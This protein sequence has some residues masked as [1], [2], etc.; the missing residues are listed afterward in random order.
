M[1]SAWMPGFSANETDH[2]GCRPRSRVHI[3]NRHVA[4]AHGSVLSH[5]LQP[6][7][8]RPHFVMRVR[9]GI[10]H[11]ATIATRVPRYSQT[12]SLIVKSCQFSS[13]ACSGCRGGTVIARLA[14]ISLLHTRGNK[15]A[16]GVLSHYCH[17]PRPHS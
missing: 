15:G 3:Q 16:C 7:I 8:Y 2:L 10:K 11:R 14:G 17:L 9:V 12:P 6:F 4:V 1:A 5:Y 13:A